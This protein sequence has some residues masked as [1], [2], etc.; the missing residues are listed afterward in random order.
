MS[1]KVILVI[2]EGQTEEL[3]LFDFLQER[4]SNAEV[5]ID[6]QCG[7]IV[8]NWNRKFGTA[9]VAIE[10]VVANYL[11]LYRLIPSDLLAIIQ[12]TDTDGCFIENK[13]IRV[14]RELARKMRYSPKAIYVSNQEK[15]LQMIQR[16]MDKAKSTVKLA[17]SKTMK[18]INLRVP[19]CL[20]YFSINLDH[21]LWNE[22]NTTGRSKLDKAEQFLEQLEIPLD[23][24]MMQFIPVNPQLPLEEKLEKSWIEIRKGLNSLQRSTNMPF[25]LEFVDSLA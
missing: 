1:K 13:Y 21:V 2:V 25:V 17:C 12:F 8:G 16:N 5:R 18:A 15:K 23:Q 7:D 19:Y 24:F 3:I 11:E 6:I 14:D 10:D 22:Q 4:F 9:K 20:G